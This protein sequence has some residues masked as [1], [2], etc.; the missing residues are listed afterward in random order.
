MDDSNKMAISTLPY[1]S[2]E[3]VANWFDQQIHSS[4]HHIKLFDQSIYTTKQTFHLHHIL[5]VS[6][7]PF[8]GGSGLFYLH[9]NQGLFA[10][11]IDVDPTHFINAY[12]RI[13]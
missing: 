11:P 10:Y 9:T 3:R 6:Y 5:D 12:K 8:S 1:N 13:K 2:V 7:R 4:V